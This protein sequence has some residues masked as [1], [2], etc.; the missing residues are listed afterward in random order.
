ML[1][2]MPLI[3]V[4]LHT[5]RLP[6]LKMPREVWLQ[7]FSGTGTL[8]RI[9]DGAGA[10]VPAEFDAFLAAEGVDTA[11]LM[12]E[13]SPKVT[14]LQVIEDMLPIAAYAPDRIKGIAHV[15]THL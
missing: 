14:G 15:S 1:D 10:V 5:A 7:G 12:S 3:D 2:G 4:H 9:Y 11:L 8:E 6:T 13:Y